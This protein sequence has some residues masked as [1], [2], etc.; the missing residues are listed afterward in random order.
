MEGLRAYLVKFVSAIA[1][2]NARPLHTKSTAG[3]LIPAP[4]VL[5]V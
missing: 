2:A 5:S 4:I 1:V 3:I